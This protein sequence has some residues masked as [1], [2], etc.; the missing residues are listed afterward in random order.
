L[1]HGAFHNHSTTT[2]VIIVPPFD[3]FIKLFFHP[4]DIISSFGLR[5][6]QPFRTT[7]IAFAI[8]GVCGEIDEKFELLV[9][10]G[11]SP[12]GIQIMNIYILLCQI[13]LLYIIIFLANNLS[14][15]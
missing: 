8:I 2:K 9:A 13:L 4:K 7:T 6:L 3:L 1:D 15:L 12:K 14:H 11:I 10:N 5:M